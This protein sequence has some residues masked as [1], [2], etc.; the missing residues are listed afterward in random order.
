[1][2]RKK[3]IAAS[4]L[5]CSFCGKAQDTVERLISSPNDPRAYICDECVLVCASI[6]EGS[7]QRPPRAIAH[8]IAPLED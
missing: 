2:K 5:R 1:M 3:E 8:P 6:I 4:G 7:R